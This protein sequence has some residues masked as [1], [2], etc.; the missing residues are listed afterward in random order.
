MRSVLCAEP[1][2]LSTVRDRKR[3]FEVPEGLPVFKDLHGH[4]VLKWDVGHVGRVLSPH[5]VG[6]MK[7]TELRKKKR[8]SL[9]LMCITIL[10]TA[11]D[12]RSHIRL[13]LGGHRVLT[14]TVRN[15]VRM[16]VSEEHKWR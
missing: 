2:L 6:F 14:I 3:K 4:P 1:E 11:T 12:T 8:T 9:L 5:M 7:P 15:K 16:D 10:L 13:R